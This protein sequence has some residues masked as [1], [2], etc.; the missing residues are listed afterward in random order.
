MKRDCYMPVA[1]REEQVLRLF[2]S[3]PRHRFR[4]NELRRATGLHQEVLSRVLR[5]LRQACWIC[6]TS[7]GLYHL[8]ICRKPENCLCCD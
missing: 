5:R 3:Y 7:E 1:G 2:Q 4:F 8:C 6:R